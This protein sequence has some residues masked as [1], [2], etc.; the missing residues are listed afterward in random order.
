MSRESGVPE[1][2]KRFGKNLKGFPIRRKNRVYFLV[3]RKRVV[4]VGR[5]TH[6]PQ[7]LLAH[8]RDKQFDSV[9]YIDVDEADVAAVEREMISD[10]DPPMNR[11]GQCHVA[12]VEG[13]VRLWRTPLEKAL[14]YYAEPKRKA[15]FWIPPLHLEEMR[16]LTDVLC[17]N[18]AGDPTQT[19]KSHCEDSIDAQ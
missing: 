11:Q 5:T 1:C 10:L 12:I 19:N 4:Y 18:Q 14:L 13:P 7:R 8:T 3:Q 9:F 6:L 15:Y 17:R 2:L 16:G